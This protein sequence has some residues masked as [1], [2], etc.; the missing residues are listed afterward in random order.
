MI[1]ESIIEFPLYGGKQVV[2]FYGPT[3]DKPGRHM[4]Y[5][6]GKRL[7]GVTSYLNILDKSMALGKWQQRITVEHLLKALEEGKVINEDLAIEAAIQNDLRKQKAADLGTEIH[8]WAEKYIKNKIGVKG[9]SA[10][11]MPE[12][13]QV[14]VGVNSFLDWEKEHKVKF[15]TSERVVYSKKYGYVGTMDIEAEVDK[16]LMM[17]DL[18]S[19]NGLYNSVR[20]QTEAYLRADEEE[21]SKKKYH[22]RWAIR[23]SKL[24][25]EEYNEE[26]ALK[27]KI[28]DKIAQFRGWTPKEYAAP[29]YQVFEAKYLDDDEN[30]A[31]RDFKAFLNCMSLTKWNKETDK[32]LVGDK[33]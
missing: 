7:T 1:D 4:Y 28:K 12:K 5:L 29:A 20:A 18:K 10:P 19:S 9:Y 16:L 15:I 22:G 11:D 21:N 14:L 33:W 24:T 25:E 26:E 17:V 3:P 13:K 2:K 30:F 31:D 23:L 6:N 8:D 27:K 32:F